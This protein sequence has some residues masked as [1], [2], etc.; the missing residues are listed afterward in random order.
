MQRKMPLPIVAAFLLPLAACSQQQ[1]AAPAESPYRPVA[2]I[3]ELM[4]A[5]VDPAADALWGAVG[6]FATAKGTED[7]QP[8]TDA[9]WEKVKHLAITLVEAT[10]L[11]AIPGRKVAA[12]GSRLD[13]EELGGNTDPID[14]EK[15][16]NATRESFIGYA[17][18]LH[19]AAMLALNAINAKDVAALDAAGE[20]MDQACENC[21][22]AYWY[23][24]APEPVKTY[25]GG[26]PAR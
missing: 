24:N 26:P 20:K 22:R 13:P 3:Q 16:I 15:Q 18:G 5:E 1:T 19:D 8:R 2:T 10:N 23:P 12:E 14:I 17:H 25:P 4:D 9:D 7:R 11:L 6:F 21:H